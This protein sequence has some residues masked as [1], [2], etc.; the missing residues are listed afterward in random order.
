MTSYAAPMTSYAAPMAPDDLRGP[1]DLLRGPGDFLRGPDDVVR[2]PDDLVRGSRVLR[3]AAHDQRPDLLRC[4]LRRTGLRRRL[5]QHVLL[6]RCSPGVHDGCYLH[7]GF[8]LRCAGVG[9]G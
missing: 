2:G 3:R 8:H 6:R 4:E 7:D 9:P 1:D 5:R